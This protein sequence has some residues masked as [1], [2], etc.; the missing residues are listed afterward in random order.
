MICSGAEQGGNHDAPARL[1]G[2]YSLAW[3]HGLQLLSLAIR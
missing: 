1:K 3:R 2:G